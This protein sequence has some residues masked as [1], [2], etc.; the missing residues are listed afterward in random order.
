VNA[1]AAIFI[2]CGQD[3]AD[4]S[5]CHVCWSNSEIIGE[6]LYWEINLPNLLVGT[7]GGGTV[8]ATQSECLSIMGCLGSGCADKFAELIAATV[9]AGEFPTAA[10][11]V[12]KS[13]IDVHE[14]YGRN[15]TLKVFA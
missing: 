11:V 4:L 10:A 9:L 14:N 12:N 13:Y 15:K 3:L 8:L 2:A 1:L 7:V 5:S 6:E